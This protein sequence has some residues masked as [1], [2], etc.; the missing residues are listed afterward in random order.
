MAPERVF[1]VQISNLNRIVLSQGLRAF[2]YGFTS[3]LLGHLLGRNGTSFIKVGFVLASIV[4][5][6]ALSSIFLLK[7]GENL[8]R[9]K[10]YA[11]FYLLLALSGL[12]VAIHPTTL[13]IVLIALTGVLSTDSNDNGPATTLEQTMLA[14]GNHKA[15]MSRIFGKYN[16]VASLFGALGALVQGLLSSINSFD[17]SYIGFVVLIPIG[18]TCAYLALSLDV[19]VEA[20]DHN[21][22][23]YSIKNSPARSHI[24]QLSGLF[25]LDA[26][27]GGLVSSS[28]LAYYLTTRY[29]ASGIALGN[30]FFATSILSALSMFLAPLVADRI[31]LVG[32]M[33]GTHLASNAFLIVA[34]F[35]GNFQLAIIFLLLRSTLSQ[36]DVPTRQALI[37]QVVPERDRLAAAAITNASRYAVRP[38][39]PLA[40]ALLQQVSIGMPLIVCGG[41]KATYDLGVL[42]WAKREGFLKRQLPES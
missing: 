39:S 8:G 40:G 18:L 4:L 32:T 31:G 34:A 28:F 11:L 24:L 13:V 38:I 10:S 2:A 21:Q 30:L 3:V 36:M 16:G 41:L 23:T 20:T 42:G 29:E 19:G 33:V 6:A 35:C 12:L 15:L 37:A 1:G 7:F 14:Q 27:A 5:G 22:N 17:N 9:R 25:S 26:A